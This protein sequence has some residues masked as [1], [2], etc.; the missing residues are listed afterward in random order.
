[1]GDSSSSNQSPNNAPAWGSA[2]S[3]NPS[4]Q[5]TR[6]PVWGQS[7]GAPM[8]LGAPVQLGAPTQLGAPQ[9]WG[10]MGIPSNMYP[11]SGGAPMPPYYPPPGGPVGTTPPPPMPPVPPSDRSPQDRYYARQ[12]G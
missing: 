3:Y 11:G 10:Q 6:P 9:G 2:S 8:Q 5:Y 7:Y 4:S 12:T 1:M